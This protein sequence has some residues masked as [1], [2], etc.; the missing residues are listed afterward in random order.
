MIDPPLPPVHTPAAAAAAG[1]VPVEHL[2]VHVPFCNAKCHYCAL[3]S[4]V[5]P[6][7]VRQAYAQQPPRELALW[8]A[9]RAG[10]QPLHP[11]TVYV[12]G[13]SPGTLGRA[14]LAGLLDGLR[15]RLDTA[16]LAEWTVELN[17]ATVK[18]DLAHMLVAHGVNRV[19]LGMQSFDDAVLR[20]IGRHHT[21]A[22]TRAA[23]SCLRTAGLTNL[24]LDLIAGLPE[25]DAAAWRHA[26]QC[27]AEL[28]LTHVSVYALTL[29]PD[30]HLA[31]QA[32]AGL[33]LP[34]AEAQMDALAMAEATLGSAGLARYE[35]S[36]Y[37]RPGQECQHNLAV[38]RG[39]DYLGLGP[40]AA[41]RIGTL[42]WTNAP[43]ADG[44]VQALAAGRRPPRTG[45]TLS[46]V[47][48][49]VERFVF[50]LRLAEGVAPPA[51]AQRFPA[52]VA[53][54]AE[55]EQALARCARQG[56]ATQAR[57]GRWRLTARGREVADAVV[58][59][60]M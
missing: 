51:F 14:G 33:V 41:S 8:Q 60:L 57:D 37:A 3:Y 21:V 17:P 48:D 59:E 55:W 28:D 5:A 16:Q 30:T 29:E 36:N 38:W 46:A 40:S 15:R 34:D 24:G 39:A 7:A 43:D 47:D 19:S 53:R 18:P 49:A 42:R 26:L 20:A 13:G 32:A 2:Y 10:G 35:L 11:R 12:G 9:D 1:V 50:G 58:R 52:A 27:A 44:Y 23:L 6:A 45:E 22:D 54:L 31:C 4:V 56:A 25:V